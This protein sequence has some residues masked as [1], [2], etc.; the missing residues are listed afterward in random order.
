MS[1]FI[2]ILVGLL[3]V[4]I[5]FTSCFPKGFTLKRS[6]E[7]WIMS[8]DAQLIPA[9]DPSII[10][11]GRTD[12]SNSDFRRFD[13][14][15]V[16]IFTGFEG[17]SLGLELSDGGN[18]YNIIIDNGT[19]EVLSTKFQ[20]GTY[21]ITR[22]LKNGKHTVLIT[23][24]TEGGN[25]IGTFKGFY[26]EAGKKLFRPA[27]APKYKI[28]IIG[29]SLTCGYGNEGPNLKCDDLRKYENNYMAYGPIT[30]RALNA[31]YSIIAIS[32]KGIIRNYGAK[33]TT[34][35][36]PL[37]MFYDRTLQNEANT[38]WKFDTW[39]PDIV[40]INLGTNDYSTTPQPSFEIFSAA[41]KNLIS[42]IRGNYP[43]A[44]IFLLG[45][46]LPTKPLLENIQAIATDLSK[47]DSKI[48]YYPLPP[49]ASEAEYGCDWHPK[50]IAHQRMAEGLTAF[51]KDTLK[52]K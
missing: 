1:K 48:F 8:A 11:I 50:V 13:W 47:T 15:G 33:E 46:P 30:A 10:Y 25:G 34:S 38:P 35:P 52:I 37:P 32:G 31:E 41:Y 3:S 44:A 29:D 40:L 9:S 28:E 27:Y 42:L 21:A 5:L 17:A 45:S 4:L 43:N 2:L 49:P 51:I 23:K 24:R 12:A 19:P 20:S 18:D 14:P 26:L 39:L 22:D 16:S 36:D 6:N 7:S